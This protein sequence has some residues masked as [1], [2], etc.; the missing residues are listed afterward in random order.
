[1]WTPMIQKLTFH[2]FEISPQLCTRTLLKP[3]PDAPGAFICSFNNAV[4]LA[5]HL[6]PKIFIYSLD[7]GSNFDTRSS[8]SFSIFSAICILSENF[9]SQTASPATNTKYLA[10]IVARRFSSFNKLTDAIGYSRCF[11]NIMI[12]MFL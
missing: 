11:S 2:V 6:D 7:I 10:A 1:M 4:A 3:L 12:E 8:Y 5:Q 9:C